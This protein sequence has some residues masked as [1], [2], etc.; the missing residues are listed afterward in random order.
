MAIR[1]TALVLLMLAACDDEQQMTMAE[2]REAAKICDDNGLRAQGILNEEQTA[3]I[4]V[5][6]VP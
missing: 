4:R 6:C 3:V 5:L 1:A 2:M